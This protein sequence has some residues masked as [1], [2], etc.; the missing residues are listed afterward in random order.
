MNPVSR[1]GDL[2]RLE[3]ANFRDP[4]SSPGQA[5]EE[6]GVL[7]APIEEGTLLLKFIL[8]PEAAIRPVSLGEVARGG[9]DAAPEAEIL[10]RAFDGAQWASSAGG[11]PLA[12]SREAQAELRRLGEEIATEEEQEGTRERLFRQEEGGVR[13]REMIDRVAGQLDRL[14]EKLSLYG[15]PEAAALFAKE[16]KGLEGEWNQKEAK[17]RELQHTL[18]ELRGR[19]EVAA[20]EYRDR[21]RKLKARQEKLSG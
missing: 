17:A 14:E 9:A 18:E 7:V 4:G 15:T 3:Y 13:S 12:R 10:G 11:A 5:L 2:L 6:Q 1:F 21:L 20:L 19:R 16:L 8:A